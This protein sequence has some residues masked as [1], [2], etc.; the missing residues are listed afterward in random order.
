MN[1]SKSMKTLKTFIKYLIHCVKFDNFMLRSYSQEGEDMILR[2]LF[3]K[4]S[5][6]FYVDVGAHHPKRFSNT[7]I[8]YSKGWK[9]INIDA[10]PGSM[11]A[12]NK[13]RPRD[14][15][16]EI[17]IAK[18]QKNLT[19]FQF[20]EPALNGFCKEL[21]VSRDGSSSAYKIISKQNIE[22]Y[23][24]SVILDQHL[25]TDQSIDFLSV[26]VEGLDLE[27]LQSNDWLKFRPKVVL[28]E[29]LDSSLDTIQNDAVYQFLTAHNYHLYA[30]AVNTVFFIS[31][32]F[33]SERMM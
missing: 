33:L 21:A 25:D 22:A 6:G 29:I 17:S 16:L 19:Y 7:F 3:E 24:L 12:F 30:K 28:V 26:D 5:D 2:R 15:N 10:M 32:K 18:E 4:Q 31:D 8:F 20:N 27:V 23:P 13:Q 11:K 9:G 14:K 1:K